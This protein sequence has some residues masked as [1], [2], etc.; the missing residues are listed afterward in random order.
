MSEM[1]ANRY[2]MDGDA[3]KAIELYKKVLEKKPEEV[4]T[5]CRLIAALALVDHLEEAVI[6]LNNLEIASGQHGMLFSACRQILPDDL[7]TAV[8]NKLQALAEKKK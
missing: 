4:K 1:L 3:E 6:Q 2:L 7:V 5:R 8:Q